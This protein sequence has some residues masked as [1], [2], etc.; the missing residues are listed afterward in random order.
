[1]NIAR[2]TGTC[3]DAE[4]LAAFAEGRVAP[5]IA[6]ALLAH[7]DECEDCMTTLEA[8]NETIAT[9]DEHSSSGTR[10]WWLA[11][12]AV[13]IG[14][15]SLTVLRDRVF[16]PSGQRSQMA[17]LIAL[18]PSSG[19]P[20]EARLSGGFAWSAYRG[21]V[22]AI[23]GASDPRRL[24]LIGVA[25]DIVV[26]ADRD[27][28]PDAQQAAGIALVV[29]DEPLQAIERLRA[30]V[31]ASPEDA[32]AWS[33]LAAAQ[34][35]AA[36]RLGRPS[37]LPE[38]L[39][40]VDRALRIDGRLP[41]ARFNRAL[42]LERL[43][44]S[45]EARA[46]WQQYLEID[47]TSAWAAEAR[48]RMA[49]LPADS[50]AS[51]FSQDLPRIENAAAA[52]DTPTID[53]L[54]AQHAQHARAYAEAEF[55]GRW[56][57]AF[58]PGHGEE[59]ERELNTARAIG[60]AL[61]RKSGESLLHDAVT[62]ID[63]APTTQRAALGSAHSA[64]RRGRIAY[65]KQQLDAA[66]GELDRAAE[67]F[68]RGGSPM[69]LVARYYSA[70]VRFDQ[71]DVA[72]ASQI[73][74]AL[75]QE[76][77]AH[78]RFI[79]LAAQV[80]WELALCRMVA[81][82]WN[83]ALPLFEESRAGFVH[84]DERN[85]LGFIESLLA[86]TLLSLG[87]PDDAWAARIRGFALLSADGR[88]DRLPVS[89]KAAA[90]MEL[91][92]G[93]L[94]TARALIDLELSTAGEVADAFVT[95][96]ALVRSTLVDATLG[97]R[98]SAQRMLQR[99]IA[100]G[101]RIADPSLRELAGAHIQLA[102]A[103]IDP[104]ADLSRAIDVYRSTK[105]M[106]FLPECYL[107]RARAALL[108]KD[109]DAASAELEEGI[110]ILEASPS[111]AGSIVGTGVLDAGQALF[112]EAIR[113]SLDRGDVD[114]AL[115]YE[116]RSRTPLHVSA[117]EL[118]RRLR[119]RGVA[120]LELIAL[121]DELVAIWVTE[122]RIEV[123]RRPMSRDAIET[124]ARRSEDHAD[125][126]ALAEWYD[127]IIRPFEGSV[128]NAREIIVIADRPMDAVP[129]AALYD[130]ATQRHL[131]QRVAVSLAMDASSLQPGANSP[132]TGPLLAIALPSGES[133][134]GL[135]ETTREI[136]DIA[137]MYKTATTI[138]PERAT[139]AAFLKAAA[140]ANVIHISGHTQAQPGDAGSALVFARERVTWS[141]IAARRLRQAPV[142]VLAACETL[143]QRTSAHAR[144]LTLGEGFLATGAIDVIGTLSPI[145]DQDAGELFRSIHAHL[146]AGAVP[147][148]A[149]RLAQVESLSRGSSVWRGV[150]SLTRA[151]PDMERRGDR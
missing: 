11:A 55:L 107:L 96:D 92:S 95:T 115:A 56:A 110:A 77:T 6:K 83:G 105:R 120:V 67:G 27:R 126:R 147:A 45:K 143:Y 108:R 54:V 31:K 125:L 119:N 93:R 97:D 47:A 149:V 36:L 69:A 106:S 42:I 53:T 3:P 68:G 145:A 133:N 89:M 151:I 139:F 137:A 26:A 30:A 112:E 28:S 94:D 49:K 140:D 35:A 103:A 25:G 16:P 8:L 85:H 64:Y 82:D 136:R 124:L 128:E 90:Q 15:L 66:R 41:E 79:A 116:E 86:D 5:N 131:I 148:E 127:L 102:A 23:D 14:V 70:N 12:A 74:E 141:T 150:A 62:A 22:R 99:A 138:E 29:I 58:T 100:A 4:T 80:R 75:L 33:D 122:S 76:T 146:A 17:R 65:S 59:A 129:F 1:M 84:L 118:Q 123:K 2:S 38:A 109:A 44:L 51:R 39:V 9:R 78:P 43:G 81:G 50:A 61:L 10:W 40:S 132:A 18:V 135:P 88:G 104:A 34:H 121:P 101:D 57:E 91:R 48:Q 37:L 130:S 113:L 98:R 13:V 71:N 19:R 117:R 144:S 46:A 24:Q 73:L 87:R 111:R 72:G 60:E 32:A 21:P 114:G 134:S 7:I 52:H 142:V 20:S 63:V